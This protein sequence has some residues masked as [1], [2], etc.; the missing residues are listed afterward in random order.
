MNRYRLIIYSLSPKMA[1]D[2]AKNLHLIVGNFQLSLS[3]RYNLIKKKGGAYNFYIKW[4]KYC[5]YSFNYRLRI[6]TIL[7]ALRELVGKEQ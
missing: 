1:K 7:L 5:L 4:I 6:N 2:P 3:E